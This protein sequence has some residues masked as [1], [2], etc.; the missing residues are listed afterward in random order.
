MSGRFTDQT[1]EEIR[2]RIDIVELIGARVTLK[3]SGSAFKARCPFHNEKTPSFTVNPVRRSYHCFGCGAH[4][5]IFKFLMQTDGLTFADAV[6][7]L[8]ARASVT[9]DTQTDFEAAARGVLYRLHTEL[10]AFY[11]RCLQTLSSAATARAYLK[12]RQLDD[13]VV[14]RFGIGYAPDRAG[15]L[16]DWAS[17]NGFTV[18]QLIEGGLLAPPREER[19]ADDFYDR[20]RG[21]LIFPIRDVMGRVL[22]FSGRILDP[23]AH[24]AKYL[25]SPETPIF[26]KGRVLYAL[27]QARAS[28]VRNPRREALICEGQIDVIRCHANGFDT[29]V[30]AQGTAFTAE[31]VELLKR[32][33]D[34]VLLVFDGDAAGSHAA[35][36]TGG[37]FLQAGVPVRVTALPAGQDPDSLLR[38]QGRTAFQELLDSAVSLTAFQVRALRAV[39]RDPASID[40]V[41]RVSVQVLELLADCSK[42][43]LR[44]HLLQEAAELLH[45]PAAALEQDLDTLLRQRATRA[46]RVEGA[47]SAVAPP[48]PAAAGQAPEAPDRR[49]APGARPTAAVPP[50]SAAA[51]G[52]CELL[53]HHADDAEVM[54]LVRDWLPLALLEEAPAREVVKAALETHATGEDRLCT[55]NREGDPATRDLIDRLARGDSRVLCARD[56][57]P[58]QAAEDLVARLWVN[59]LRAERESLS[60]EDAK[61]AQRRAALTTLIKKLERPAPWPE[62]AAALGQEVESLRPG[63]VNA[64]LE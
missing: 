58:R 57:V 40:A 64:G 31:H 10:A 63:P 6:R 46:A 18:E 4:G 19:R 21:R 39:E 41:G 27:D 24:P 12:Q 51:L 44:S 29:A 53:L 62:R 43:V 55:L 48:R 34:S 1:L 15:V 13:D 45:L 54:S 49:A 47:S 33:A 60:R 22:G 16:T 42:A 38:D 56:V 23:A 36:R 25:N 8:A 17:K 7:T 37:L 2:Q 59:R 35:L 20:F 9:L 5:D 14:A 32:Y 3:R 11:V 52:L 61:Q 28:I 30:A 50:V 26:H